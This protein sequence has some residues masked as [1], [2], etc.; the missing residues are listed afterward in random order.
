VQ[1]FVARAGA[2]DGT[3]DL[4]EVN[5]AA[6]ASICRRLDGI[7]L[8]LELAA[9]R[10]GSLS[11][12]DIDARLDD[13]FGFL[14]TGRRTA[15]ARQQTLRAMVDWSYELLGPSERLLLSRSSVFAGGFALDMA[16]AV[17]SGGEID[18]S[19]VLDL[20]ASLVDKSLVQADTSGPKVRYRLLETIRQYAGQILAEHGEVDIIRHRHCLAFLALAEAAAPH[21]KAHGQADWLRRLDLEFDNCR[22]AIASS[23]ADPDAA[24]VALRFCVAL[25]RFWDVRGHLDEGVDTIE[26]ALERPD[27]LEPTTLRA[28]ALAAAAQVE[29][30]AGMM[31]RGRNR[32]EE[33]LV[34]A[35]RDGP[36]SL[37]A[38]LL[39]RLVFA[40]SRQGDRSSAVFRRAD[41]A[42]E[43]ARPSGDD[44]LI[45]D[46]LIMRGVLWQELDPSRTRADN[47]EAISS[48]HLA[49]DRRQSGI[50][51]NN[52][53]LAEMGEGD[54][55]AARAHLQEARV[56]AQDLG[57]ISR[58]P[59]LEFNAG[60][61]AVLEE[62]Y[63]A[64]LVLFTDSLL[65]AGNLGNRNDVILGIFGFALCATAAGEN[66]RAASLH[67]ATDALLADELVLDVLEAQLA[68]RD[69][70]LLRERLGTEAFV[71]AFDGGRQLS[72]KVAI[73]MALRDESGSSS[74]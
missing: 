43:L 7:P 4:D 72:E 47:V 31:T 58:L 24:E 62:D 49:G 27:A 60:L 35:R 18:K 57:D 3:F 2:R 13:R 64:A 52:L 46:A 9:S 44:A 19:E 26:T 45:G 63:K 48:F 56:I 8:A 1:L 41:E 30:R 29:I 40:A 59:L 32:A 39:C 38:D 12:T 28:E 22:V 54:Y 50:A 23:L 42:V 25:R 70:E 51:L 34:I 71:A 17:C 53:S 36:P 69:R 14:T 73:A 37:V 11:A 74:P 15:L 10:L 33:C 66:T 61:A 6:V 67:G 20:V 65:N 16:E 55:T 68:T 5:E 21:L